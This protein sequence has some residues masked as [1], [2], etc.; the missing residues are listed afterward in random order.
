MARALLAMLLAGAVL[1]P[2][3]GQ[4]RTARDYYN[5]LKAANNF[6]RYKDTFVCFA[7]DDAPSFSVMSRGS[8]I[9]NE[10]KNTGL[11]PDKALLRMKGYLYVETYY[12]GI[13][14]EPVIFAPMGRDGTDWEMQFSSP[15]RGQ[16]VYSINWTTGRFRQSVYALDQSKA[17]PAEQRYGKC[18]LI[19]P[20]Q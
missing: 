3:Q 9:I 18:E 11:A 19:H 6:N 5:E 1:S 10:M 16:I 17:I 2:G 4:P 14:N 8:D 20:G 12:K 13:G 15:F 7:D